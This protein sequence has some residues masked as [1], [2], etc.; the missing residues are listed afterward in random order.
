MPG[1]LAPSIV[2]ALALAQWPTAAWAQ[3]TVVD[4]GTFS[5][6]VAGARVGREDFS[7]RRTTDGSFVAQG[8]VLRGDVRGTVVLSTDSAGN[9]DRYRFDSNRSG[10]DE[11][12]VTGERRAILWSGLATTPAGETGREFRLPPATQVADDGAEGA[13]ASAPGN[14]SSGKE[15]RPSSTRARCL[16]A[17]W[18]SS[19]L[20]QT[21]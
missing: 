2:L 1:T 17:R 4:E 9:P 7:I 18:S 20:A 5:L 21:A 3:V 14:L 19:R 8:N 16:S 6:S 12:H 13:P 15:E 11:E 10:R